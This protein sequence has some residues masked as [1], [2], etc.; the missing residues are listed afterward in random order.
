MTTD[1]ISSK[2]GTHGKWIGDFA[3][4]AFMT[5]LC[6]GA[7]ELGI[8][9]LRPQKPSWLPTYKSD[10][11]LHW[12]NL[13]NHQWAIDVGEAQWTIYTDENGF[14]VGKDGAIRRNL[15]AVLWLGDSFA[16]G[17]AVDYEQSFVGLL[18]AER[19]PR[20]SFVNAAVG[21]WGPIQYR[22]QLEILLDKGLQPAE[23]FVATFVGNDFHDCVYDKNIPVRDG[24]LGVDAGWRSEVK[25]RSQLYRVLSNFY[26]R[27]AKVPMNFVQNEF[28][29]AQPSNW[30]SGL[31]R[32]ARNRYREEF[33]K[34][35]RVT[36]EHA[37]PLTAVI[38]PSK[39]IVDAA[40]GKT[41]AHPSEIQSFQPGFPVEVAKTIFQELGIRY[42]DLTDSLRA[43]P[44]ERTYF[45]FDGHW[46]PQGH[47]IV[48]RT[49]LAARPDLVA[50]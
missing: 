11:V 21:G 28:E 35:A 22:Q 32:Q 5:L 9:I 24:I 30:E 36:R 26:H 48:E 34:I 1:E 49:I 39:Q 29:M 23:V 45:R 7:L 44:T 46:T 41:I 33:E 50:L 31:L 47:R 3:L 18:N 8:R 16:F 37:I 12:V 10:P 38:V 2:V 14:R 43:E 15:P 40:S 19:P 42:I 27:H 6:V 25:L 13:P 17:N 4:L 20:Y